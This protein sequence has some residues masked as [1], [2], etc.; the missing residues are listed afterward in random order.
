MNTPKREILYTYA[1]PHDF[2]SGFSNISTYVTAEPTKLKNTQTSQKK[3]S[4]MCY[5]SKIRTK[6]I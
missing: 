4:F 5:K 1:A 3:N 2:P 6:L